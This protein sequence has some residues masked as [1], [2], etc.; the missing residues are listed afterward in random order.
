MTERFE[1]VILVWFVCAGFR[2]ELLNALTKQLP[3]KIIWLF[4]KKPSSHISK[5]KNYMDWFEQ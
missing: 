3:N 2:I 4:E 1:W 5:F